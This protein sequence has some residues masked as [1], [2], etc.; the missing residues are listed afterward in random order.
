VVPILLRAFS[1]V[2]TVVIAVGVSAAL[3]ETAPG[4]I[5][6]AVLIAAVIA[7]VEWL[8]IWAPRAPCRKPVIAWCRGRMWHGEGGG[9]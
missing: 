1:T 4:K 5:W 7:L 6:A 8:L 3:G 9:G 2:V